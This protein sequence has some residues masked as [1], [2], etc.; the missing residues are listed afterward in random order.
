[1][2]SRQNQKHWLIVGLCI[3]SCLSVSAVVLNS[4]NVSAAAKVSPVSLPQTMTAPALA[5]RLQVEAVASLGRW[6]MLLEKAKSVV[7]QAPTTTSAASG[8][9]TVLAQKAPVTKPKTTTPPK[10]SP[11]V[12]PTTASTS[13]AFK[14]A[15][16]AAQVLIAINRARAQNDVGRLDNNANASRMAESHSDAMAAAGQLLD[17]AQFSARLTQF[18]L[19][20]TAAAEN[21]AYNQIG[22]ADSVVS[23][24]L[25]SPVHRLNMLNPIYDQ[26]GVGVTLR[27]EKY[28]FTLDL[29][30]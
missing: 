11:S 12:P 13:S 16:L 30:R 1:M 10:A 15:A 8:G 23:Q 3:F 27:D 4:K 18:G 28:Y 19:T 21:E 17:H 14:G 26:A 29:L 9:S 22:T 20:W 2:P 24:W 25:N 6:L 7:P 5:H